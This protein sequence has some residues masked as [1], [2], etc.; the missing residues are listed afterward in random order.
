MQHTYQRQFL[1]LHHQAI[2][3]DASRH[4]PENRRSANDPSIHLA[5]SL[6]HFPAIPVKELFLIFTL[7]ETHCRLSTHIS[8]S[9]AL[10]L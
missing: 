1:S 10:P 5:R 6:V 2:T 9:G 4:P 8:L 3:S 7:Y